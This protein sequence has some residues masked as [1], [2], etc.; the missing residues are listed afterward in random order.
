MTDADTPAA[1][2]ATRQLPPCTPGCV[3]DPTHGG[4]CDLDDDA[5]EWAE[6]AAGIPQEALDRA[7]AEAEQHEATIEA[8]RAGNW[9]SPLPEWP[10]GTRLEFESGTDVYAFCRDDAASAIAGYGFGPG[11]RTWLEY[12]RSVPISWHELCATYGLEE[13]AGAVRLLVHPEDVHQ[14]A[15]RPTH[16][17]TLEVLA[18]HA[19]AE[20]ARLFGEEA[21]ADVA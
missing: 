10:D 18:G 1:V 19:Q 21:D 11:A 12:G 7:R 16:R 14:L 9:F 2:V 4:F 13:I 15:A 8:A 20:R 3:L 5:G 17:H 6:V